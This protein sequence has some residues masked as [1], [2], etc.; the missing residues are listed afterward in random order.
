MPPINEDPEEKKARLAEEKQKK[1]LKESLD[2]LNKGAFFKKE[3]WILT[4]AKGAKCD[5]KL[6]RNSITTTYINKDTV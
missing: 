1:A 6:T 4:N 5:I 2:K 3:A